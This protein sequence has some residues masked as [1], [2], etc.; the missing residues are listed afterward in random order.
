MQTHYF[1]LFQLTGTEM[2]FLVF[3]GIPLAIFLVFTIIKVISIG[4]K[5]ILKINQKLTDRN[6]NYDLPPPVLYLRA[7]SVDGDKEIH[8]SMDISK[9]KFSK[10][11][12][13]DVYMDFLHLNHEY[14]LSKTCELIGPFTAIGN[15]RTNNS[16]TFGA[17]KS[18]Y[19]NDE[20]QNAALLKMKKSCMIIMRLGNSYGEG[21]SWELQQITR[22]F[23]KKTIFY[24]ETFN[25]QVADGLTKLT[26]KDYSITNILQKRNAPFYF[27]L[28]ENSK[29]ELSNKLYRTNLYRNLYHLSRFNK[30]YMYCTN[31]GEANI[32]KNNFC[33]NCGK[34]LKEQKVYM[35]KRSFSLAGFVVS[36][37]GYFLLAVI[38]LL[39]TCGW[40]FLDQKTDGRYSAEPK[41]YLF[42]LIFALV[43]EITVF[44]ILILY[45][46]KVWRQLVI[47]LIASVLL[48]YSIKGDIAQFQQISKSF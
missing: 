46:S 12:L 2:R 4:R 5:K 7:F 11:D 17:A 29:I 6:I 35:K 47:L 21:V 42:C 28:L 24:I 20:W 25:D 18:F 45:T 19:S 26:G 1:F 32:T 15:A 37:T 40:F 30:Y 22:S 14:T 8:P 44:L 39:Q 10:I 31:C 9:L 33:A 36:D 23:L 13:P 38:F 43:L 27:Q 48:I 3:A 16:T 41:L 34:D